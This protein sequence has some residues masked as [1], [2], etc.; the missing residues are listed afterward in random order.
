MIQRIKRIKELDDDVLYVVFDDGKIVEYDVKEDMDKIESYKFTGVYLVKESKRYYPYGDLAAQVI[1]FCGSDNQGL[2]GIEA[3]YDEILKGK[4]GSISK[5]TDAK[6]KNIEDTEE[7]N[8][9]E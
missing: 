2:N 7:K 8:R 4:K 5:T 6:G 3:K 1:G 9:F